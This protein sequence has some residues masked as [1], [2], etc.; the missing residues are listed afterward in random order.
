MCTC[1]HVHV[2]V[3]VYMNGGAQKECLVSAKEHIGC[4]GN[5]HRIWW[6]RTRDGS[7]PIQP[8]RA[9]RSRM[10]R[11][12]VASKCVRIAGR[13][14]AGAKR[15]SRG[16]ARREAE[17]ARRESP[18]LGANITELRGPWRKSTSRSDAHRISLRFSSFVTC[19]CMCACN[20]LLLS[21]PRYLQCTCHMFCCT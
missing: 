4:T 11:R 6:P 3:H 13:L 9:G 21:L 18:A 10:G 1:T 14:R 15:P 2:H 17:C 7:G 8:P 19:V 12:L 16:C 20:M 5:G